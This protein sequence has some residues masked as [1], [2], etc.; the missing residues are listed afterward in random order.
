MN[1]RPWIEAC[2][3]DGD[4]DTAL[5]VFDDFKALE[6]SVSKV[7]LA[8]LES[9]CRRYK[10]PDYRVYDVCAQMRMQVSNKRAASLPEPLKTSSHHVRGAVASFDKHDHDH[11][12]E[13]AVSYTH[14]TLPTILLV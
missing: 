1:R 10:V 6:I 3:H 14:L 9:C 12:H 4:I 8:F 13:E 11:D 2:C 7:T 5:E